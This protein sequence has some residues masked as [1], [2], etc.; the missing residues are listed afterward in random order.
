MTQIGT[1]NK[2]ESDFQSKVKALIESRGGYVIK[3]HVSALQSQGEPDLVCCYKGHFVAFELKVPGNKASK[4]QQ[5]KIKDIQRAGG[6]A[7][8]T[9]SL[10]EIEVILNEI[11]RVQRNSQSD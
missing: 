3:V 10:E 1:K 2:P 5:R 8:A 9:Q 11:S 6:T 4:L 7:I